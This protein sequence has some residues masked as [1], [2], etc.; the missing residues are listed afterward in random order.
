MSHQATTFPSLARLGTVCVDETN[1]P[2]M[3][4][5]HAEHLTG[6]YVTNGI[7]ELPIVAMEGARAS[8][9]RLAVDVGEE[10]GHIFFN[11]HASILA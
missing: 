2:V 7:T 6:A 1:D 4:G 3:N 10:R 9:N 5:S 8:D 11:F